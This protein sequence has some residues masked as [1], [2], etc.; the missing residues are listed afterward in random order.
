[1]S[2]PLFHT[3]T[4]TEVTIGIII[5][6]LGTAII[7][8]AI[9]QYSKLGAYHKRQRIDTVALIELSIDNLHLSYQ[10]HQLQQQL[11]DVDDAT[12]TDDTLEPQLLAATK[13]I[14]Q[15]DESLRLKTKEIIEMQQD[16]YKISDELDAKNAYISQ[17]EDSQIP[18]QF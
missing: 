8:L 9:Y 7:C 3:P 10:L 11:D 2:T 5:A 14:E 12:D 4:P 17:L 6:L 13:M 15:L 1:M 18:P 16:Y